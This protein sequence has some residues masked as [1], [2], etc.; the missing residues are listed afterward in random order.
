VVT[1]KKIGA[2]TRNVRIIHGLSAGSNAVGLET[3]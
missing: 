2:R 3:D 1:S